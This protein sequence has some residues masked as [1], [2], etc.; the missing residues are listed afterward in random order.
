MSYVS[1]PIDVC[2]ETCPESDYECEKECLGYMLP[3]YDPL[4]D[5]EIEEPPCDDY[6][7]AVDECIEED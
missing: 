7:I 1:N 6:Y 3:E 5:Q 4:P 2:L